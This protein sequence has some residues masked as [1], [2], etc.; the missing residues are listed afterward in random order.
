MATTN[1]AVSEMFLKQALSEFCDIVQVLRD[2]L[3]NNDFAMLSTIA[4]VVLDHGC[5]GIAELEEV[6]GMLS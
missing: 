4:D 3:E 5:F 6:L 1:D 2:W